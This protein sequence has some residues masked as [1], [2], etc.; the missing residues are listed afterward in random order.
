MTY[1]STCLTFHSPTPHQFKLIHSCVHL[2]YCLPTI[3]HTYLLSYLSSYLHN[4][5]IYLTSHLLTYLRSL[6][7]IFP[8]ASLPI[9][10]LIFPPQFHSTA[11]FLLSSLHTFHSSPTPSL[12]PPRPPNSAPGFQRDE[13]LWLRVGRAR[14]SLC[15]RTPPRPGHHAHPGRLQEP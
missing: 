5:P 9:H 6:L 3:M 10:S 13:L 11:T 7:L 1:L 12:T 4:V 14:G 8:P 15:V 2:P